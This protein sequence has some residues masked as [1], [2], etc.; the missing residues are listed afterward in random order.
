MSLSTYSTASVDVIIPIYNGEKF[1]LK[2]LASIENQ[3]ILPT[4]IIVSID[5]RTTDATLDIISVYAKTSKLVLK[6]VTD[7]RHSHSSGR[8]IAI[9]AGVA[10]YIAFVDADDIWHPTKLEKQLMLFETNPELGFVYCKFDY[11]NEHGNAIQIDLSHVSFVSGNKSDIFLLQNN[12]IPTPGSI[13]MR[14]SVL[15]ASGMFDENIHSMEDLDFIIRLG[16]ETAFDYINEVLLSIRRHTNNTSSKYYLVFFNSLLF[17]E[18]WWDSMP[19]QGRRTSGGYILT[20]LVLAI[21]SQFKKSTKNNWTRGYSRKKRDRYTM[22]MK[23]V[24]ITPLIKI[25]LFLRKR[26]LLPI[27]KELL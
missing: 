3:T 12:M 16:K 19:D 17:L 8:N 21:N 2:T 9:E 6:I 14:R 13:L 25:S 22:I 4:T 5:D 24:P 15:K 23:F 10:D 7:S 20:R 18:K 1:I 11:I 26:G 27:P